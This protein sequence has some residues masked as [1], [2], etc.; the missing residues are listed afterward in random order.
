VVI[1]IFLLK[2]KK[3]TFNRLFATIASAK[4]KIHDK[5]TRKSTKTTDSP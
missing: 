5:F 2:L 1:L 4:Q 3:I